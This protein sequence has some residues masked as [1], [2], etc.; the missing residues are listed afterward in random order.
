MPRQL[1]SQATHTVMMNVSYNYDID[2]LRK[3]DKGYVPPIRKGDKFGVYWRWN[4]GGGELDY[5]PNQ[6]LWYDQL[7]VAMSRAQDELHRALRQGSVDSGE[8]TVLY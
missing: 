6:K 5:Y 1:I 3:I 2:F 7:K 4:D 8:S